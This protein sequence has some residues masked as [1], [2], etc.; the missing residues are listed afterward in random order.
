MNLECPKCQSGFAVPDADPGHTVEC[1][2][3]QGTFRVPFP[4]QASND[5][6]PLP[7]R[8]F[9]VILGLIGLFFPLAAVTTPGKSAGMVAGLGLLLL[10]VWKRHAIDQYFKQRQRRSVEKRAAKQAA[11]QAEVD[12]Q[13][14]PTADE[15]PAAD[16]AAAAASQAAGAVQQAAA[17]TPQAADTPAVAAGQVAPVVSPAANRPS[18]VAPRFGAVLDTLLKETA[19]A[20]SRQSERARISPPEAHATSRPVSQPPNVPPPTF[21]PPAARMKDEPAA[22][23]SSAPRSSSDDPEADSLTAGLPEKYR[24]FLEAA[25][26]QSRWPRAELAAAASAN[27]LDWNEAYEAIN[28]WSRER[29]GDPLLVEDGDEF[30]VQLPML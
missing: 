24:A 26:T 7:F 8:I 22:A 21:P 29:F 9:M 12:E 17:T 2:A 18:G 20:D 30:R 23:A 19:Q 11:A 1:P 27:G 25:M 6:F 4:A 10:A 16:V 28:Q 5:E 14:G 13:S 15:Q 3:C